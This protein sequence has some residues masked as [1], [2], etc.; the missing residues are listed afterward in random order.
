V[1][2]VIEAVHAV[3]AE[4]VRAWVAE[5]ADP[6]ELDSRRLVRMADA[7]VPPSVI[8]VVI[9]VSYPDRFALSREGDVARIEREHDANNGYGGYGGHIP[10]YMYPTYGRYGYYDSYYGYG[11]YGGYGWGYYGPP[12]VIVVEP[13]DPEPRAKVVKG[14]GYTRGNPP[15]GSS[16][17]DDNR[18]G[19]SNN[20]S[21][22]N[23]NNSSSNG[24]SQNGSSS[25]GS[26]SSGGGRTAKPR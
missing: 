18:N 7:G 14:R 20:G 24:S 4:A 9:A 19:S 13:R 3:D 21:S 12:S 5:M 25:S 26:G 6:F 10:V 22:N 2:D 23:S 1:D 17:N 15:S 11:G 8:D 16:V